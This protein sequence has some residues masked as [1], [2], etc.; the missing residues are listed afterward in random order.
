[1]TFWNKGEVV[2]LTSD[3]S[4]GINVHIVPL[5]ILLTGYEGNSKFMVSRDSQ[6]VLTRCRS[7]IVKIFNFDPMRS[8]ES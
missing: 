3:A 7:A 8:G 6:K 4:A 5:Y 1:M 2:F